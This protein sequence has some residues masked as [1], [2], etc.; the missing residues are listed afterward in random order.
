MTSAAYS[1]PSPSSSTLFTALAVGKRIPTSS[2]NP[3]KQ[4]PYI[5]NHLTSIYG[6]RSP[7]Y[8]LCIPN[9]DFIQ[10]RN[11]TSLSKMLD[12]GRRQNIPRHSITGYPS[13]YVA[14][15]I[16]KMSSTIEHLLKC[17][18]HA[19]CKVARRFSTFAI[20]IRKVSCFSNLFHISI[21]IA[22]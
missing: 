3:A 5:G 21:L 15:N 16:S 14:C 2:T 8:W 12:I 7:Y 18:T 1:S 13:T 20:F 22:R 17:S 6:R 11:L 10:S 9:Q 4:P 19:Y